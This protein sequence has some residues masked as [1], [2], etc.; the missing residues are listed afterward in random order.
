MDDISSGLEC[1]AACSTVHGMIINYSSDIGGN[2]SSYIKRGYVYMKGRKKPVIT[3]RM[4]SIF[5]DLKR[6]TP[7]KFRVM[8]SRNCK[9]TF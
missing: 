6:Q 2:M 3:A 8:T 9:I 5:Q 7:L 4:H 1:L